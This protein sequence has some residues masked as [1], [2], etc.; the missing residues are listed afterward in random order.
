MFTGLIE[1]IGVIRGIQRGG[2]TLILTIEAS[3]VLED[4]QLGDSIAVNGVCL[5]VVRYDAT[6]MA[7]DVMPETYRNTT[8]KDLSIGS[9]VNLERAMAAK[10]RFG[11]HVV[12]GHVDGTGVIIL[13]K[14]DENAVRFSIKPDD[15]ELF[16]YIIERG[17]IT[18]DGISLTVAASSDEYFQVSI[19]PHTLAE[20]VLYDKQSG[21][22]V[23]IETD[24]MGKYVY[25]FLQRGDLRE[26][27]SITQSKKTRITEQYLADQGFI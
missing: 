15:P 9:R 26:Q 5:T 7:M 12:Q 10:G 24:L 11:G 19:I 22:R 14:Q 25:H 18:V 2:Q 16:R 6:T 17:S 23:N 1:E 3:K 27:V 8:L 4:V 21:E 13:R 20:T